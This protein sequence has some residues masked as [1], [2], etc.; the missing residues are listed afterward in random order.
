MVPH[1]PPEPLLI[2]TDAPSA[3]SCGCGCTFLTLVVTPL[4]TGEFMSSI[5]SLSYLCLMLQFISLVSNYFVFSLLNFV[6]S[7]LLFPFFCLFLYI[8]HSDILIFMKTL[9][10][11]NFR[12]TLKTPVYFSLFYRRKNLYVCI[13]SIIYIFIVNLE[14]L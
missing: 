12:M 6:P 13:V 5:L 9:Y 2:P 1:L 8:Y 11:I 3:P 4:H 10:Y 7:W 14:L